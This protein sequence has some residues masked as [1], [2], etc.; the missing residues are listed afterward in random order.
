MSNFI[1]CSSAR[2]GLRLVERTRT[3]NIICVALSFQRWNRKKTE[4][5]NINKNSIHSTHSKNTQLA[6][7]ERVVHYQINYS[8]I[9]DR[10]LLRSSQ[11]S[12]EWASNKLSFNE[13]M[14][15]TNMIFTV[16]S[17]RTVRKSY[18]FCYNG[19]RSRVFRAEN[20]NE[21]R[22]PV[23]RNDVETFGMTS[24]HWWR[25]NKIVNIIF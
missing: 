22:I 5:E 20:R 24:N 10:G 21:N 17:P 12:V 4:R 14:K 3:I 25:S 8:L 19:K 6:S 15:I 1:G 23:R 9:N 13:I 7:M 2:T 11:S 18:I 16:S